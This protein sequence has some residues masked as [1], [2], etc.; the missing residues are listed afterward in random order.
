MVAHGV[1]YVSGEGKVSLYVGKGVPEP[2]DNK[3]FSFH[4]TKYV[5]MD[6]NKAV[7]GPG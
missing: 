1:G 4:R 7:S 5:V 6:I 2:L 3:P